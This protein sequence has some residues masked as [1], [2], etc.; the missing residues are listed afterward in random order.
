[1]EDTNIT[2]EAVDS[3]ACIYRKANEDTKEIKNN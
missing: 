3:F 2:R 1:M